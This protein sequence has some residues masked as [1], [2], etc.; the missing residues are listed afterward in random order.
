MNTSLLQPDQ[1]QEMTHITEKLLTQLDRLLL[2]RSEFHRMVLIGILCRGHILF[3]GLP[4]LGKTE[5]VRA[6][7]HIMHLDF[8]RIQFTPDLMPSDI[9][10]MYILQESMDGKREMTFQ[11]GPIFAHILC[12]R[13]IVRDFEKGLTSYVRRAMS[14]RYFCVSGNRNFKRRNHAKTHWNCVDCQ[15]FYCR[16]C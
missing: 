1:M 14:S 11:P 9:L 7:G 8:K 16:G 2:G 6:L 15:S 3:E 5:L 13:T 4:G 10:G 12:N